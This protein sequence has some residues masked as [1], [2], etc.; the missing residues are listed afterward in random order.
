MNSK[1]NWPF[2]ILCTQ[3]V[4]YE[5]KKLLL[6]IILIIILQVALTQALQMVQS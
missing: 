4:M 5:K 3:Q 1:I 2:K 6:I